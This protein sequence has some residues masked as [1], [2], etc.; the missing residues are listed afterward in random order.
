MAT[1]YNPMR[2][3]ML[4]SMMSGALAALSILF[5]VL[6]QVLSLFWLGVGLLLLAVLLLA[7]GLLAVLLKQ[8]MD[9]G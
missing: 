9:K 2:I 5:G 4:A 1:Y 8:I 6:L 7:L 3:F